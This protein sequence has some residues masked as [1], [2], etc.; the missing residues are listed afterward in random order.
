[1]NYD[2][3]IGIPYELPI[4]LGKNRSKSISDKVGKGKRKLKKT[5][6]TLKLASNEIQCHCYGVLEDRISLC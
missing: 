2:N 4:T 3:L 5:V 6:K 1:M